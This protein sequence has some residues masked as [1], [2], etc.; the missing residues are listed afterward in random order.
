MD[1][2]RTSPQTE[3]LELDLTGLLGSGQAFAAGTDAVLQAELIEANCNKIGTE[4]G[5]CVA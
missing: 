5:G 4:G 2:N 3:E 1:A